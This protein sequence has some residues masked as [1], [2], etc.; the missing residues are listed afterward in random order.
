MAIRS[1]WNGALQSLLITAEANHIT[2]H[3]SRAPWR[4][5]AYHMQDCAQGILELN[6]SF[7]LAVLYVIFHSNNVTVTIIVNLLFSLRCNNQNADNIP[8]AVAIIPH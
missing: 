5:Q 2:P 6:K 7:L 4:W 1:Q 8:V 3:S